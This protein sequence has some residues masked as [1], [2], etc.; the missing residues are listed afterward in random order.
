MEKAPIRSQSFEIWCGLADAHNGEVQRYD[1]PGDTADRHN[2]SRQQVLDCRTIGKKLRLVVL[3]DGASAHSSMAECCG[4]QVKSEDIDLAEGWQ[5]GEQVGVQLCPRAKGR[6]PGSCCA[7]P[8]HR[9]FV[10]EQDRHEMAVGNW[11][12]CVS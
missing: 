2:H 6:Q 1:D 12:N 10:C 8:H 7:D 11:R 9:A 5:Y 3:D 4:K